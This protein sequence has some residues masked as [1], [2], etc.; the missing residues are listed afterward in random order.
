MWAQRSAT[1]EQHEASEWHS[2]PEHGNGAGSQ[3]LLVRPKAACM[4]G[5]SGARM[6]RRDPKVATGRGL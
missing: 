3:G 5:G 4:G 2:R 6:C 1:R